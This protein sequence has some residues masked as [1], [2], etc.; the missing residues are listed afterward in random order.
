MLALALALVGIM[1]A[2]VAVGVGIYRMVQG[3]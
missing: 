1:A 3:D 2:V